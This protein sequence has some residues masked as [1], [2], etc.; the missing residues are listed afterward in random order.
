[1]P[2]ALSRF[3]KVIAPQQEVRQ[4]REVAHLIQLEERNSMVEASK[5]WHACSTLHQ[6]ICI[7]LPGEQKYKLDDS[8][9]AS[10]RIGSG[11]GLFE[12]AGRNESN[13]I[14]LEAVACL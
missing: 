1:M 12:S 7:Y 8:S 2:V 4:G 5:L 11:C 3:K 10:C 14:R 9:T 13:G 6:T